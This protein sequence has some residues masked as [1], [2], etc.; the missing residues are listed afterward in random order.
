MP[1]F[2]EFE[3]IAELLAPLATEGSFDLTDDAALLPNLPS[4]EAWVVTKDAMVSGTHLL[5]Y[6]P[7]DMIAR[8]LVGTNLSDL[9]AMG[10]Q[11]L[12]YFLALSL[13]KK[14]DRPWLQGFCSGLARCQKDFGI[15][16]FGG[17]TTSTDGML[18]LSLTALGT[19]PRGQEL[20]RNGARPGD[21]V[22]VTGTLGDA[23]FGL[24]ELQSPGRLAAQ[25][26]DALIERYRL[27][28]PRIEAG[29]ALRGLASAC[30]DL[31]DGLVADLGH[32]AR[33]S[34]CGIEIDLELV[35]LSREA[36]AAISARPDLELLP[37]TGG[38]DYEL[39]FTLP[40]NAT[41]PEAGGI[42]FTRIGRVVDGRSVTIL[43]E[44]RIV[45][46]DRAGWRHF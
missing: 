21:T 33:E 18:T 17:D 14:C 39:V 23:A 27:P 15:G 28:Q 25:D 45:P 9:A 2:G 46:I 19:V 44:G 36:R 12:G 8:K 30:L 16:L 7:P 26:A 3:F 1:G 22:W 5:R 4:G 35:P 6:D 11:P 29:L 42:E 34:G 13:D 43:R 40:E 41:P 24:V 38:D 20:R 32:M 10:A 37:I 31:S